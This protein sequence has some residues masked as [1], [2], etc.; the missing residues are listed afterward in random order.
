[1]KSIPRASSSTAVENGSN[2][3]TDTISILIVII[4][5]DSDQDATVVEITFGDW[6][7]ALLDTMNALKNLGLNVFKANVFLN[8]SGKHN[9]ISITKA[10][11]GRKVDDLEW[12]EIKLV[13]QESSAP[14]AIGATFGVVPPQ[15]QIL[16]DIKTNSVIISQVDVDIATYINIQDDGPNQSLLYVETTDQPELLVDLV[17]SITNINIAVEYGEL[18]SKRNKRGFSDLEDDED[19]FFGSKKKSDNLESAGAGLFASTKKNSIEL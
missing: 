14:L 6:L 8:S 17:K 3:D 16:L 4:D 2:G 13:A 10:D 12:L 11:T 9:R 1:M 5:Q 19:D 15:Q 7:G 18:L